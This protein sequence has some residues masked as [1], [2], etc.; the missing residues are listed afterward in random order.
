MDCVLAKGLTLEINA[1]SNELTCESLRIAE[2]TAEPGRP[3]EQRG[4]SSFANMNMI[5]HWGG[6]YKTNEFYSICDELGIIVW[7]DF[8]FGNEWQ[9]GTYSR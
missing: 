8:M 4:A 5:R 3:K 2:S 9:P 6:G 1:P 7:Q